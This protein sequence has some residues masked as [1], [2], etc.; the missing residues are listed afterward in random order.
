MKPKK[1]NQT[2]L[3][4]KVRSESETVSYYPWYGSSEIDE[5]D[6]QRDRERERKWLGEERD[7]RSVEMLVVQ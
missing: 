1:P 7:E 4:K 5:I 6:E 3:M 2:R